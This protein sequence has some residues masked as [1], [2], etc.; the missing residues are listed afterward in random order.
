MLVSFPF[1]LVFKNADE[2]KF[3]F[4]I[5]FVVVKLAPNCS[6]SRLFPPDMM[7]LFFLLASL[8]WFLYIIRFVDEQNITVKQSFWVSFALLFW[9]IFALFRMYLGTWLYNYNQDIFNVINYYLKNP[10]KA[11]LVDYIKD[12]EYSYF[13]FG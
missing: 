9:S 11:G 4:K 2:A 6:I 5:S 3:L 8:Q 12:W 13:K 7:I 1:E 10:V